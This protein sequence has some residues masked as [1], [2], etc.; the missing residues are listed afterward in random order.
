MAAFVR[1]L[2]AQAGGNNPGSLTPVANGQVNDVEVAILWIRSKGI[3]ASTPAGWTLAVHKTHS[4]ANINS[5]QIL[6]FT[7][8]RAAGDGNPTFN[9]PGGANGDTCIAR[10][11][12]LGGI[13]RQGTPYTPIIVFEGTAASNIGPIPIP[14]LTGVDG[15][16]VVVGSRSDDWTT[17]DVLSS[18][19]GITWAEIFESTSTAGNDGGVVAAAGTW[20]GAPPAPPNKTFVVNGGTTGFTLGVA[21]NFIPAILAQDITFAS[22]S[23]TIAASSLTGVTAVANMAAQAATFAGIAERSVKSTSAGLAAQAAL[24]TAAAKREIK[25]T[26][27]SLVAVRSGMAAGSLLQFIYASGSTVEL[28][29]RPVQLVLTQGNLVEDLGSPAELIAGSATMFASTARLVF[30]VTGNLAGRPATLTTVMVLNRRAQGL[31]VAGAAT[32][33]SS[34]ERAV[35]SLSAALVSSSG[36]ISGTGRRVLQTVVSLVATSALLESVE[37]IDRKGTATLVS[38][39]ALLAAVGGTTPAGGGSAGSGVFVSGASTL[40][41]TTVLTRK[42]AIA[43]VSQPA[44]ILVST[45]RTLTIDAD[46]FAQNAT[47]SAF[48]EFGDIATWESDDA[49]WGQP[50]L[51]HAK[52]WPVFVKGTSFYQAEIT[53]K[54]DKTPVRVIVE[55]TGLTILGRDRQGNWKV[56]AGI[57]K[58]V[59]GVWPLFRGVPGT[60]VLIYVG[61]QM[62]TEDPIDWEGPY[63]CIIGQTNFIDFTVSGRYIA[64]RFES[65]GEAPWELPSYDLDVSV[66]GER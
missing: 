10:V 45:N 49:I 66:V 35:R 1:N 30:S 62:S 51:I 14:T 4:D 36:T 15:L 26:S 37:T 5:G 46:L 21:I 2:G 58:F 31:L 42:A 19:A 8:H 12:S 13:K 54:F 48:A 39:T 59:S 6:V 17:V 33:I 41:A 50:P 18:D 9:L 52:N 65:L 29:G 22:Q 38:S 57:I 16:V 43:L 64:L 7:R 60:K 53:G 44:S 24:V 28:A 47:F 34:S 20:S 27:A 61:G 25:S 11:F 3:I 56:D 63:E 40:S 55:R 32:M 23:A